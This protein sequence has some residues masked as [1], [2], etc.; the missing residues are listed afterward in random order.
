M[1]LVDEQYPLSTLDK[2]AAA[3]VDEGPATNE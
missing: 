2:I 3:G 1:K